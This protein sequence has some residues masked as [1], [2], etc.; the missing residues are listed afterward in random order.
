MGFAFCSLLIGPSNWFNLP[1]DPRLVIIGE[2]LIGLFE[3]LF[4]VPVVPEWI[5]RM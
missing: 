1:N 3:V 4:L 2:I 5:E